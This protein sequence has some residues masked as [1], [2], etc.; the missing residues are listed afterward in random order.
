MKLKFNQEL[1][2]IHL[3][4]TIILFVFTFIGFVMIPVGVMKFQQVVLAFGIIFEIPLLIGI[5]FN[6]V[7]YLK[8]NLLESSA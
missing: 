6:V 3:F 7:Y 1:N 8:K 2:L 5:V 4:G